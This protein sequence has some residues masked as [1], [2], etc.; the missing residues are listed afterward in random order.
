MSG[1]AKGVPGNLV[2]PRS[3]LLGIFL[4]VAFALVLIVQGRPWWCKDG[5]ALW[6]P[7]RT[8]CTS[9]NFLDPYSLSHVLHGVLFYGVLWACAARLALPWRLFA[10][11]ALEIGW[12]L[13]EN[14]AWVIERYRQNTAAFDYTGDSVLNSL[15][16]VVSALCGFVFAARFN[17]KASLAL[18][19]AFELW[20]LY[21][22]R[23]NLTLNV[24]MLLFP[25][26]AI[27]QWQTPG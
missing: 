15:G 25:L 16:D 11:L 18:F 4:L 20:L 3:A 1:D 5:P 17:W 27:K 7:V 24:L 6:S 13:L 2:S 10:A 19:F 14:S 9:Q 23:D 21:L 22:S 26:E 8:H 12:E